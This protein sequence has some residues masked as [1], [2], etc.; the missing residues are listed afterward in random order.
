MS[1][2]LGLAMS[3][4]NVFRGEGVLLGLPSVGIV[5]GVRGDGNEPENK[6]GFGWAKIMAG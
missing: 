2:N 1:S 4:N 5:K 3:T 6:I